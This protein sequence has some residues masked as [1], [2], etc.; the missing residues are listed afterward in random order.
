MTV[1]AD[2]NRMWVAV[3]ASSGKALLASSIVHGD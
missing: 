1:P 3:D 2:E